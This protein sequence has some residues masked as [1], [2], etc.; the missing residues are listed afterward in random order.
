MTTNLISL[1]SLTGER[2]MQGHTPDSLIAFHD[3]GYREMNAR[4]K[5]G[6]I[7]D[8]GCGVG[9]QTIRLRAT[10][11]SIVGVDY[12]ARTAAYAA[13]THRDERTD[14]VAMDGSKIGFAGAVFDTVCSSHIIEHFADPESHVAELARVCSPQ[15]RALVITPNR[16]ADFENPFHITLF[17]A[18]ELKSL[19]QLFFHE[20]EILGL[21]GT[22]RLHDDFRGRRQSGERLLKL[23]RFNLRHKIPRRAYVWTYETVLPKVY[24]VLGSGKSGIGSGITE[25]EFFLTPTITPSTPG[26]F[27]IADR[28]RGRA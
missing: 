3:A 15:G 7:L 27:A 24:K 8:V 26:L 14:F 6:R 9:A 28:P 1:D 12:H 18:E 2:P 11:R 20:V 23:D 10:D 13:Q 21:E 22:E 19:L 5:T 25:D 4:A 16:P 17:E